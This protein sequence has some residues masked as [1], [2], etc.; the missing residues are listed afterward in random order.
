MSLTHG[1]MPL[2]ELKNYMGCTPC[3]DDFDEFWD[4]SIEEMQAVNS[5]IELIPSSFQVPFAECFDL[6]FTG[7]GGARVHA[8]YVRPKNV[9]KPHPAVLSFHGYA[10]NAG[11]WF[12]KL[13]YASMGYCIAA[14]DCRGQ[15]GLSQDN[16]SINGPTLRGHVIRGID[17]EPEK[18]LFRQIFLDTAQLAKIVM[19]FPEVDESYVCTTGQS[20]GGALSLVCGALEPRIKKIAPVHPY[21]S[22]YKRFWYLDTQDEIKE[23]FRFFDPMHLRE[24]EVFTKLGYIDIQNLM[25][26]I[27]GTVMLTTGLLDNVCPPSTQFAAYNK[28]TA[29]KSMLIYHDYA[30]E[31]YPG[32]SDRILQFICNI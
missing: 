16:S 9:S 17:D 6:Y 26:R 21:L 11:D 23:Y 32:L 7:V 24:D 14:L 10:W 31:F 2:N 19:E 12:D 5:D 15:G 27:K 29:P 8:K 1:D 20:Q 4:K 25:K 3:P 22:D 18:M 28:I 30:H 13:V